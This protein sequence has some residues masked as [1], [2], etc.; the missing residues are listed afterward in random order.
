L[1][2]APDSEASMTAHRLIN[3]RMAIAEMGKAGLAIMVLGTA[4]CS[5]QSEGTTTIGGASTTGA[6]ATTGA[7][8]TTQAPATSSTSTAATSTTTPE[9][10]A[11]Q[12]ANLDFVSAY[13]LYRG[14]EAALVDTGVDGSAAA[15]E[16]ALGEAGLDWG[17]VGHVIL[18][19]KH[20]DH[21]GS[22]D[23]VMALATGATLYAGAVEIPQISSATGPQAVGD[24]DLVFDLQIIDTPGHTA[25]HICVLDAA[26]GILVTGDALVGTSGGVGPPDPSF[27][28]DMAAAGES[29]AKLAGFDYEIALFGHGEPML[30]GASTAVAALAEG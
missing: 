2:I 30:E 21:A 3:R 24:G 1:E 17:T 28:E 29:I 14:G 6:P 23:D 25:G 8:T 12:R 18:T 4:A 16:A 19:H 26:A 20:P 13:I 15:I 27:S 11:F 9:P 10:A 5:D 7:P 22:V